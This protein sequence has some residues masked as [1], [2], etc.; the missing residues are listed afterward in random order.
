MG[1]FQIVTGFW[2]SGRL[3]QIYPEK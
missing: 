3:F 2:Y 1:D